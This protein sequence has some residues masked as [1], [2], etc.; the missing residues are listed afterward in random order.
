MNTTVVFILKLLLYFTL[1]SVLE[2]GV[3]KAIKHTQTNTRAKIFEHRQ[4]IQIYE[5][6]YIYNYCVVLGIPLC[7]L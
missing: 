5:Y 6:I 2:L 7:K 1:M 4:L 3:L